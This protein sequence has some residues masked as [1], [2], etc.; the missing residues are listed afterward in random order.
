MAA[1][2]LRTSSGFLLMLAALLLCLPLPWFVA[3]VVAALV[4][5]CGHYLA[6]RCFCRKGVA[7]SFSAFSARMPLPEMG[8][9]A[10]MVCAM[11]GPVAGLLLLLLARWLP[12]TAI[13]ALGQSVFNLLPLYPLDGGRALR[14]GLEMGLDPPRVEKV[15]SI[16]AW[17]FRVILVCVSVYAAFFLNLGLLPLLVMLVLLFR[18]K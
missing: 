13:C 17:V 6:I 8:R 5:E 1:D 4:H 12:R 2:R 15:C 14:C 16:V 11:A 18:L 7:I 9:G 3:A 10:E